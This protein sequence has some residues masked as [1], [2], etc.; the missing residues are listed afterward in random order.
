M[1]KQPVISIIIPV[2][3]AEKYLDR[4]MNSV[5]AQTFTDFECILVDDGSSDNTGTIC[6]GYAEKDERIKVVH[7]KNVGPAEA[8]HTGIDLA[9][10][11]FIHFIDSDDWV[12][13]CTLELFYKK[14]QETG[15][16]IVIEKGTAIFNSNG[17]D[18]S[19]LPD[20][21][22]ATLPL[23]YFFMHNCKAH[24]NKLYKKW[25]FQDL[26]YP[27][28]S[29]VEDF[30]TNTQAFSKVN[31]GGLAQIN[32][33]VYNFNRC[34]GENHTSYIDRSIMFNK[35][36]NQSPI[37]PVVSWIEEFLKKSR[38]ADDKSVWAAFNYLVVINSILPYFKY[39]R[40]LTKSEAVML[41]QKYYTN[42]DKK[43]ISLHNKVLIVLFA[44]F[45]FYGKSWHIFRF[46]VLSKLKFIKFC[47]QSLHNLKETP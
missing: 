38:F 8:R 29:P 7:Q 28:K 36:Y 32:E 27:P 20:V 15:A 35:P 44:R 22:P 39:S 24:W 42:C 10:A 45:P 19:L 6:D 43:N 13:P 9:K 4:C 21:E 2:Y 30:I 14:Q 11:D 31:C 41:Y 46:I 5:F 1:N 37:Y 47:Y 23:V 25:L 26:Y 3:N 33:I 34:D 17:H 40:F 18:I 12:E 16:D